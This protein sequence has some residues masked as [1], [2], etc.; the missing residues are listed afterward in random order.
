MEVNQLTKITI[1]REL[2]E[3]GLP[4]SHIA[5][6]QFIGVSILSG[7]KKGK[8]EYG[9]CRIRVTRGRTFKKIMGIN[10]ALADIIQEQETASPR[11]SMDRAAHS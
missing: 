9:M 2:Y 1:C 6:K 3:Q 4:K 5:Q 11:S 10:K 7:K 8:L